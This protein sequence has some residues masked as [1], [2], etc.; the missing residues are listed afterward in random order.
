MTVTDVEYAELSKLSYEKN[1]EKVSQDAVA[2]GFRLL[3][4]HAEPSLGGYNGYVFVR[5]K[6]IVFAHR[7]TDVSTILSSHIAKLKLEA[8]H[9]EA[10]LQDSCRFS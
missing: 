9:P 2:I 6:D 7:G 5:D 4:T 3:A 1:I 10:R 8:S